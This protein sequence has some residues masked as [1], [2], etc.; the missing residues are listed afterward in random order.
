MP[1]DSDREAPT[2]KFSAMSLCAALIASVAMAVAANPAR[3]GLEFTDLATNA[4]GTPDFTFNGSTSIGA[5]V[6]MNNGFGGPAN[7]TV[8]SNLAAGTIGPTTGRVEFSY[9]GTFGG[10]MTAG[11]DTVHG[12]P[13]YTMVIEFGTITLS[14]VNGSALLQSIDFKEPGGGYGSV[15]NINQT[16]TAADSNQKFFIF[17]PSTGTGSIPLT[18]RDLVQ[19]VRIGF[20]T[21]GGSATSIQVRAVVNPEPGTI[22]LFAVGLFGLAGLLRARRARLVA[23][24]AR[25]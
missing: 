8:S 12:T 1:L 7:L 9:N 17:I 14:A 24:P 21:T 25:A 2:M 11:Y 6:A 4:G 20:L 13:G 16:L 19:S 18:E 23:R 3:A 15:Y 22:A 5:T 10:I